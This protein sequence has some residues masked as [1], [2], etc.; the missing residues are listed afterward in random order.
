MF[1]DG[2]KG[3]LYWCDRIEIAVSPLRMTHPM[4]RR[5][6]QRFKPLTWPLESRD[7]PA[8]YGIWAQQHGQQA[9]SAETAT[10]KA[11]VS[12]RDLKTTTATYQGALRLSIMKPGPEAPAQ[13]WPILFAIHGG[14]WY[15]FDRNNILAGL[16][17][18]PAKGVA[19]VA[20]DYTLARADQASWPVN[21]ND[22]VKA[23][24]WVIQNGS[25]YGLDSTQI[26]V[27]GQSAGG[28]LAALL[29]IEASGRTDPNGGP[30][31]DGLVSLS[32]PMNLPGLVGES[33]FAANKAQAMI[34]ASFK[35]NP[36]AWNEASPQWQLQS[37][38]NIEMPPVILIHGT[39]DPV[40]PLDQSVAFESLLVGRKKGVT[41]VKLEKAGHELLKGRT[42][43]KV[44]A[45]IV[46]FV[47]SL[48]RPA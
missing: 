28:H 46:K 14:G 7:C 19:V 12:L 38:P 11:T 33:A 17:E 48:M 40:V 2:L 44:Q 31:V 45:M 35:V 32:G 41:M 29:A 3:V 27:M 37:D 21:L 30:L 5:T 16:K 6:G 23:L 4:N 24:D 39:A 36:A 42:G 20:A 13:G 47:N 25:D 18:I 43:K 9:I 26:T 1:G 34:G 10:N 22:L 15:R 8:S